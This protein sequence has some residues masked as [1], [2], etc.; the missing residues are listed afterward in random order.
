MNLATLVLGAGGGLLGSVLH[1]AT[2]WFD[3]RNKIALLKAQ[4]FGAPWCDILGPPAY[5]TAT[6]RAVLLTDGS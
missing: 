3:T 5:H 1:C 4:L 2:D 6:H